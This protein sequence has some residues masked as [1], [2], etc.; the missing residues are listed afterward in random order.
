MDNAYG[1]R[2]KGSTSEQRKAFAISGGKARSEKMTP[3]ER[4]EHAKYMLRVRYR[5]KKK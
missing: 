4:S 3:E 1:N 5:N 2:W